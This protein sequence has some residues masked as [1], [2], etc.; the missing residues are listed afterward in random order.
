V[1]FG[2]PSGDY[3]WIGNDKLSSLT[4]NVDFKLMMNLQKRSNGKWYHAEWRMFRVQPE[5]YNYQ[6]LV[7]GYSGDAGDSMA[8]HNGA[9]F[10]THDRDNDQ[11]KDSDFNCAVP[12]GGGFWYR[13]C[14]RSGVNS[15]DYNYLTWYDLTG[16]SVFIRQSRMWLL[17]Q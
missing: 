5:R 1:G 2:D 6:L 10:S 3:D 17:C 8:Y 11:A 15:A 13:Y 16:G 7:A 4:M 9:M 12:F 14:F